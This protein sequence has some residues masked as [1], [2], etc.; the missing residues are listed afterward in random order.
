MMLIEPQVLRAGPRSHG[1]PG[2]SGSGGALFVETPNGL[3]PK[4]DC[5]NLS[6]ERKVKFC[7]AGKVGQAWQEDPGS[8]RASRAGFGA[9]PKQTFRE[10]RQSSLGRSP[11]KKGPLRF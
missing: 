10:T 9:S 6:A 3:G 5:L 2:G 11:D 8:A 7:W 1:L 4:D